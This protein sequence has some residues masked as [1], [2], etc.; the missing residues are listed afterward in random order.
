MIMLFE[1]FRDYRPR[2][3]CGAEVAAAMGIGS[4]VSSFAGNLFSSSQQSDNV[5]RQLDAQR[6]ENAINRDWQTAEAEKARQFEAGQTLQQNQFQSG[7][8]A[9]QQQYNLQ[10]MK[11]Q[12]YYNSPV[13]QSQQLRAAGINPQVY[14]GDKASFSGSS[15][16]A[17]GAPSA[18]TGAKSPMPVSSMGLSPVSYQPEHLN[19]G[20]LAQGIAGSIKSLAEAKKL[21]VETDWL[22]QKTRS[23]IRALGADADLKSAM[24]LGQRIMNQ[25][26]DAKLPY[27][28]EMAAK[29]L[30]LV[31]SQIEL[32]EQNK[33]TADSQ[34]KVNSALEKLHKAQEHL[35]DKESQKLGVEMPYY[36]QVLKSIINKNSAETE[37]VGAQKSSV[38]ASTEQQRFYNEVL[39][40]DGVKDSLVKEV[41]QAGDKAVADRKISQRQA[42]QM[43]YLVEQAAYATDMQEFTFWSNQITNFIGTL[44]NAA[45]QFY[46]AG[47]LR[48]LINLR[49][50]QGAS[51]AHVSG[52][53][54]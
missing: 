4:A 3:K 50:L 8:Q 1:I 43:S 45:S 37:L 30:A 6:Q 48:E 53:H 17:G 10:S 29:E 35:T 18:P 24:A 12:A 11:Q 21:G 49:K 38:E 31:C 2:M 23:E 44:G 7:L 47:A 40:S 46:G 5:N 26:N 25:I 16:V 9:Q 20:T 33:I 41:R 27:A 34:A 28:F 32:N 22:D 36:A 52:F 51:P 54:P 39:N 14:F 15:P 13:Y 42:E 19:L